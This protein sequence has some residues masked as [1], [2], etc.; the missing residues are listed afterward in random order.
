MNLR[1]Y[2]A[3]LFSA[4]RYVQQKRKHD[5]SSIAPWV[6]T[7]LVKEL[8]DISNIIQHGLTPILDEISSVRDCLDALSKLPLPE[9]AYLQRW[10]NEQT[11]SILAELAYLDWHLDTIMAMEADAL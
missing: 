9:S 2:Q 1:K 10:Y 4:V 8:D 7:A 5:P 11:D 6:I 3:L